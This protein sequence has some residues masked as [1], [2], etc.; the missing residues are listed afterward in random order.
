ME[1]RGAGIEPKVRES[2][3]QQKIIAK[4]GMNSGSVD[5]WS[6]LLLDDRYFP[7]F[8][9][10]ALSANDVGLSDTILFLLGAD[11]LRF[12]TEGSGCMETMDV[13]EQYIKNHAAL[14]GLTPL[15][16]LQQLSALSACRVPLVATLAVPCD[17][18]WKE[19][20]RCLGQVYSDSAA[21]APLKK[22]IIN[23]A[24]M[25]LLSIV[26]SVELR[27]Y[28][29][30][31]IGGN[32]E[33][34]ACYNSWSMAVANIEN[35]R[36]LRCEVSAVAETPMEKADLSIEILAPPPVKQRF[37]SMFQRSPL[38]EP[39]SSP[40]VNTASES[41][42]KP[43]GSTVGATARSRRSSMDTATHRWTPSSTASTGFANN[44]D[45]YASVATCP[46]YDFTGPYEA[47][48]FLLSAVRG[49]Q[50]Q[51]MDPSIFGG[52]Q[53]SSSENKPILT[54]AT[55]LELQTVL[56]MTSS[57]RSAHT[58]E[59]VEIEY[60]RICVLRLARLLHTIE[61]ETFHCLS[62]PFNSFLHSDHFLDLMGY[63]RCT[64][65][66][67]TVSY[68]NKLNFLRQVLNRL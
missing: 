36:Y 60:A 5:N 10:F 26:A 15:R 16:C 6:A 68:Q 38:P 3:S 54:D 23:N 64:E 44:T 47:F 63:I 2:M 1:R 55:R 59:S 65:S 13:A 17:L 40:P 41:P 50:S 20:E 39:S 31:F 45:Y 32:K 34:I 33:L 12:P 28:F 30:K 25:S 46:E 43:T 56:T 7:Y 14:R 9:D 4:T 24:E 52:V 53:L 49:I 37:L 57:V 29:E 58:V 66:R 18:I 11:R 8:L 51:L 42:V 27:P 67:K 21:A 61:I 48:A 35:I 19:Y 22:K 62:A